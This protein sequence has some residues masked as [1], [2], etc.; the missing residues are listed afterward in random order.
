MSEK[1]SIANVLHR[2][3]EL[4][5]GHAGNILLCL[6]LITFISIVFGTIRFFTPE[7]SWLLYLVSFAETFTNVVMGIGFIRILLNITEE[8]E[9]SLAT[10]FNQANPKLILHFVVGALISIV[11]ICIG[12]FFLIIPGIYLAIRLQFLVYI[13]LKQSRPDF[14]KAL[15]ISWRLTE[16]KVWDLAALS[17]ISFCFMIL[18]L[19]TFVVG[20]ILIAPLAELFSVVAFTLIHSN[21][22]SHSSRP[23]EG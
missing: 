5:K 15:K 21:L 1:F 3:W 9:Y 23:S 18:G 11:A 19:L 17:F 6:F 16:N 20:I 7:D 12:L 8:K 2:S 14:Y 10:L 22:P 13:L 4:Y